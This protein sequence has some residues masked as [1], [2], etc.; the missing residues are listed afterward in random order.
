M[1][2]SIGQILK[3]EDNSQID[4]NLLF[5]TL[6]QAQYELVLKQK[7]TDPNDK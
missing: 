1:L 6:T 5:Y 7:K 4:T 3:Q 2:K